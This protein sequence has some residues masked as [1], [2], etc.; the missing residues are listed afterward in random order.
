MNGMHDLGGM[1]GFGPVNP[2]RDEPVFHHEWER[3]AF[4]I[5]LAA[6]FLG[7]WNIDMSRF[8]R[9]H[10]PP[11]EYL[12]T[13]YYEHWLYG[14]ERLLVQRGLV[15]ARELQTLR[16]QGPGPLKALGPEDLPKALRNRRAARMED[17]LATPR[18]KAGDRVRTKNLNPTTHTRLPRYAR[19]KV[20]VIDRD[21]GVFIFA[22]EHAVSG[23][24]VPQHCYAVRFEGRELWGPDAGPRDAVYVDLFEPYLE[25]AS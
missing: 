12:T 20:G 10:M 19:D 7:R 16:A 6:G 8:A 23:Q 9:E 2:E 1:H 5:N 21:H 17:H 25:P 11:G 3:R 13:T 24:K 15:S 14:L 18:F 4:A 22:D